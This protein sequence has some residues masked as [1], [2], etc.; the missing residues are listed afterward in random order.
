MLSKF[1]NLPLIYIVIF[2]L[3]FVA[4]FF[5][6]PILFYT[7]QFTEVITIKDKYQLHKRNSTKYLVVNENDTIYNLVNVWWKGDFD[8]SDDWVQMKIGN[9][10]KIQGYGFRFPL[11]SWYK[12]IHAYEEA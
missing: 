3:L 6:R 4:T 12:N 2:V 10:Y 1:S 8:K 9:T 5:F 7:T 11:L